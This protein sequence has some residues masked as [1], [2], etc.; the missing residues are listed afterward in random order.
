MSKGDLKTPSTTEEWLSIS[1]DFGETWNLPRCLGAMDGK[2]I[3]IGCPNLCGSNYYNYKG[4]YSMVL[5]TV[6]D[7]KYC[8]ISHDTG[9]SGSNNDSGIPNKI[10]NPLTHSVNPDL[11]ENNRLDIPSPTT[12]KSCTFTFLLRMKYSRWRLNVRGII[13][14]YTTFSQ[15][16]TPSPLLF[17]ISGS[18]PVQTM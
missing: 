5:L 7:S 3:F 1:Q 9:H 6:W 10:R 4:F 12:Y 8:F 2:N 14:K 13:I 15:T 17:I 16:S 18:A 11:I